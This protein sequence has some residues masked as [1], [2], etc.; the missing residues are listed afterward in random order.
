MRNAKKRETAQIPGARTN[1]L[2]S[3]SMRRERVRRRRRRRGHMNEVKHRREAT[4]ELQ[5]LKVTS[6]LIFTH[7]RN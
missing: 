4:I 3:I 7:I 1:R 2:T 5:I 6:S